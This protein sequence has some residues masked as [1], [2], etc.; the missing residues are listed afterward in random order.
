[1]FPDG[2]LYVGEITGE[3]EQAT[4]GDG[5]SVLR[6]PVEWASKGYP[7]DK[8]PE[9]VQQKLNT[10]HDLVDLTAV[11]GILDGLWSS[12]DELKKAVEES[13]DTSGVANQAIVARRDLAFPQPDEALRKRLNVHDLAWLNEVRD[14]LWDERQL[15]FYG[16]PGTGKTYLAQE[17]AEF[18]GGGPE[19]VKL[20]QFHPSYAYE[21]F[22]EGFR[23][24]EDPD[25]HE[26]ALPVDTGPTAR[27]GRSSPNGGKP[28]HSALSDHRRDQPRQPRQGLRRAVFPAGV[29]QKVGPTYLLG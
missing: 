22:F 13:T 27:T 6:R 12:D 28:A 3:A 26:V 15:V 7:Y 8:L 29:P 25:T 5:R 11:K 4:S 19:H 14:L 24:R 2:E 23:P 20:I 9:E 21:D 18:L 17:L 1:V 16:P 10:G